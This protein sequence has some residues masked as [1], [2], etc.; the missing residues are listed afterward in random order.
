MAKIYWAGQSCFQISVSNSKDHSADIVVDPY[1]EATGPKLPNLS[2]D[3]L[4]VTH[5]HHD[6]NNVNDVKGSPFLIQGPG[7]YEVKGVFV[8]GIPSFHDDKEGKERGQNTIYVFEAEEMRFC[9]MG[10]FGQKQLTDEQLEKIDK[11][12]ILMIPVGGEYTIDSSSAQK[13]ISQIEPKVVI[14]MHYAIPKVKAKLDDVSKFLKT[15]GKPSVVP[16]DKF[17]AKAS[18]MPKDGMEIVV[19]TP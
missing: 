5:Q 7:E 2:A 14:P 9:H 3:I 19:L 10:D 4:L 15:M 11:V 1:D 16:Q 6:H 17:I 8:Q 18:T 13:I 12:D